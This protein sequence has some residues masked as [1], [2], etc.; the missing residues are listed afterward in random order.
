MCLDSPNETP[1]ESLHIHPTVMIIGTGGSRII[2]SNREKRDDDQNPPRK[3]LINTKVSES[4]TT[5]EKQREP[6]RRL[7]KDTNIAR[8]SKLE[9]NELDS[10][11]WADWIHIVSSKDIGSITKTQ[12]QTY[13]NLLV[14]MGAGGLLYKCP[15]SGI[16]V[17]SN[18][19]TLTYLFISFQGVTG[20]LLAIFGTVF[21]K[22]LEPLA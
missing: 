14:V 8:S 15:H 5:S 12:Q 9:N 21:S 13:V 16:E 17:S 10:S 7:A 22:Y 6:K 19:F 20:V 3:T 1:T 2:N 18:F 11:F 4:P